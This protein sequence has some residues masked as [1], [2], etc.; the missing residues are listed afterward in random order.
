V[1]AAERRRHHQH[2]RCLWRA[3]PHHPCTTGV[4]A[5]LECGRYTDALQLTIGDVISP[6]WSGVILVAANTRRAM[7]LGLKARCARHC[8]AI[9][10]LWRKACVKSPVGE[11]RHCSP[12]L[13]VTRFHLKSS[14]GCDTS[15]KRVKQ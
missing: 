12:S 7:L 1:G 3:N 8:R 2:H 11:H 4:T 6:L 14:I 13:T 5:L 10:Y 15:F 9:A